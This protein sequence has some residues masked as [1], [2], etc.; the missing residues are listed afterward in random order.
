MILAKFTTNF[1]KSTTFQPFFIMHVVY[2][3]ENMQL[4]AAVSPPHGQTLISIANINLSRTKT[5]PNGGGERN[6]A[7]VQPSSLFTIR[8]HQTP[9]WVLYRALRAIHSSKHG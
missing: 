1:V 4:R 2:K 7:G 8:L 5:V 6:I 9:Q 3:C